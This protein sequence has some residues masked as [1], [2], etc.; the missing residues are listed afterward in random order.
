MRFKKEPARTTD[1]RGN[2]A[3]SE[4]KLCE[5]LLERP[6]ILMLL[7]TTFSMIMVGAFVIVAVKAAKTLDREAEILMLKVPG[8]HVKV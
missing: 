7:S 3:S 5:T 4:S 8:D 6:L 2:D 1:A